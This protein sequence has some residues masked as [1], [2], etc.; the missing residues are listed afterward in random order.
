[1]DYSVQIIE[2]YA[3]KKK[4][5]PDSFNQLR[6]HIDKYKNK[7]PAG[8]ELLVRD[9]DWFEDIRAL[10]DNFIHRGAE[11]LVFDSDNGEHLFQIY[12]SGMRKNLI[13]KPL[14]MHNENVVYFDRFAGWLFAMVLHYL[15]SLGV[16]FAGTH[17]PKMR[18]GPVSSFC[19][20]F[21]DLRTWMRCLVAEPGSE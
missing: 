21:E 2:A 14:L 8:V 18:V 1:M 16:L 20:G 3:P 15:D 7:L 17:P 12:G 10:R 13:S 5:L 11:S 9:A 6:S 4:Q 19:P